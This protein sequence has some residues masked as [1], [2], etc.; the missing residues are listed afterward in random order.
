MAGPVGVSLER[1]GGVLVANNQVQGP[2]CRARWDTTASDQTLH[3]C[4]C[5]HSTHGTTLV[6]WSDNNVDLLSI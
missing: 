2:S 6:H 5:R 4:K 3:P 1:L